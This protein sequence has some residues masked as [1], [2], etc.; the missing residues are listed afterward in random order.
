MN[1]DMQASALSK[2]NGAEFE[3]NNEADKDL[4]SK[5]SENSVFYTDNNGDFNEYE[6]KSAPLDNFKTV[7]PVSVKC[8]F[9]SEK[10]AQNNRLK[11][12]DDLIF[13]KLFPGVLRENVENDEDFKLFARFKDKNTLFST[14]Y[15]DYLALVERIS[16]N[17]T[18]KALFSFQ[19]KA[20][21]PGSLASS[22]QESGFYTKEQV[23]RMSREEIKKNYDRIRKSQENW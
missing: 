10:P 9:S 19:N 20:S 2:K 13:S 11:E 18:Q 8:D 16:Q 12:E 1:N 21:S 3:Q 15:S 17:A 14:L 6:D 5:T 22:A 7:D 4:S 23:L